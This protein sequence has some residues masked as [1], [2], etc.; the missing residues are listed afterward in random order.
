[1]PSCNSRV[2]KTGHNHHMR[3]RHLIARWLTRLLAPAGIALAG[4][5]Y[6]VPQVRTTGAQRAHSNV[7]WHLVH[8][9]C[10]PA[11]RN[12]QHPPRPCAEVSAPPEHFKR[13]YAVLKDIKGR[14]QYLV[15]PLARI[16]G[17]ESPTVLEPGAPDYFADAW[18]ARLYVEAALHKTVPRDELS[19]AVNSRYGRTQNQLHIHVDCIRPSVRRA[20]RR[21]RSAITGRWQRLPSRL[22]HHVYLAKWI[23]GASLTINPF[24]SLA[25]ALPH[26][27]RM[28]LYGLAV[29]GAYSSAGKPGFILLATRADIARGNYGSTEELQDH[30]CA[31]AQP[32]RR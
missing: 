3:T 19:L 22:L 18:T 15:L 21:M 12:H 29:I 10:A 17:I 27:T 25:A 11:A 14:Y 20:L 23:G 16:A 28:G 9:R 1:M 5:V 4:C 7:L 31:I 8:D 6:G 13:G 30:S 32:V 24:R 26:G 2:W